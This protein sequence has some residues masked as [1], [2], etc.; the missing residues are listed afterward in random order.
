MMVCVVA[1]R[2]EAGATGALGHLKVVATFLLRR[3]V[4]G[5]N[6]GAFGTAAVEIVHGD[7]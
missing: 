5:A 6:G 4:Q 2:L 7:V 3:S 1:C